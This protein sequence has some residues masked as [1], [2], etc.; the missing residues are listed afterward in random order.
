MFFSFL[1]VLILIWAA[2]QIFWAVINAIFHPIRTVKTII[3]AVF[4][5]IG[6]L[7]L[8]FLFS[9]CWSIGSLLFVFYSGYGP[10]RKPAS[11]MLDKAQFQP[12]C[13]FTVQTGRKARLAL[14]GVMGVMGV[15]GFFDPLSG[16]QALKQKIGLA[17]SW[18]PRFQGFY[19]SDRF[20]TNA[21]LLFS[22]FRKCW[23]EL[24]ACLDP[25]RPFVW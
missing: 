2:C 7:I 24:Q 12:L 22:N 11:V 14:T 4:A 19:F 16:L 25:D 3:N 8:V 9:S 13:T 1:L 5:V 10:A 20:W 21:S 15:I 6:I 17:L 23:Q 18:K